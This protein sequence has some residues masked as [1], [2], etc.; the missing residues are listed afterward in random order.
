MILSQ[1]SRELNPLRRSRAAGDF[2]NIVLVTWQNCL[3]LATYRATIA[4]TLGTLMF[5]GAEQ[6]SRKHAERRQTRITYLVRGDLLPNPRLSTPWQALYSAQNDRA[7]ITTM[8]LDVSTFNHVLT[9]FIRFRHSLVLSSCVM[10]ILASPSL[11]ACLTSCLVLRH[12]YIWPTTASNFVCRKSRTR[13][14][15]RWQDGLIDIVVVVY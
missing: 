4:V 9:S 14:L 13:R 2:S 15:H 1:V 10:L 3:C 5:V 11:S 6:S 12:R 8:G 7:F